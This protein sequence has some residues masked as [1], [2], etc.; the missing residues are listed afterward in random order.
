MKAMKRALAAI[1]SAAIAST[2]LV[3]GGSAAQAAA[4]AC[5]VQDNSATRH[6]IFNNCNDRTRW[7]AWMQYRNLATGRVYTATGPYVA[8]YNYS[9]TGTVPAG[10]IFAR[11]AVRQQA[12]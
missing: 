8:Y 6:R 5:V 1:G 11:D 3:A 7:A 4:P 9:T 2:M 12:E 10:W